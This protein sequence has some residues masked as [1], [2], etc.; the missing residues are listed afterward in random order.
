MLVSLNTK[1]L[2]IAIGRLLTLRVQQWTAGRPVDRR[3]KSA[4]D[5]P[6]WP[7]V[8]ECRS[9]WSLPKTY[10]VYTSFTFFFEIPKW[11]V[12]CLSFYFFEA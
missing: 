8:S 1:E 12:N 4:R 2:Q 10:V 5:Y 3:R 6:W 9:K 11:D 7:I